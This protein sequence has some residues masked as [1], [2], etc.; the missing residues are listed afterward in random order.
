MN[1]IFLIAV[2]IIIILVIIIINN[3]H[4]TTDD[5]INNIT[6]M[7]NEDNITGKNITI[8]NDITSKNITSDNITIK[9][10]NINSL[11]V[12][13]I[14]YIFDTNAKIRMATY[15]YGDITTDKKINC[16]VSGFVDL[17]NKKALINTN[18]FIFIPDKT[19][20]GFVESIELPAYNLKLVPVGHTDYPIVGKVDITIGQNG[21]YE[22]K[23]ED[24]YDFK[25]MALLQHYNKYNCNNY[26][27][28][29]RASDGFSLEKDIRYTISLFNTVFNVDNL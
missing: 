13:N 26:V 17:N 18:H 6:K 3:E 14:K 25:N 7:I 27:I 10:A 12:N 28:C 21:D 15:N 20:W 8:T 2:L 23:Y 29:S 9:D 19:N 22:G 11:S 1:K 24:Q 4:F 5:A 16:L